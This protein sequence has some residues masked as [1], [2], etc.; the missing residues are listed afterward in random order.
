MKKI[1][2]LLIIPFLIHAHR[3]HYLI[4]H[5][6]WTSNFSW[7]MPGG[8]FYDALSKATHPTHVSFFLWSGKNSPK[9]RQEAAKKLVE[10]LD[11]HMPYYFE[12]N[13]VCH[14]HGSNVA[15]MA[16]QIMA[17]DPKLHG[18][19]KRLFSLGTPVQIP[20][21]APDM[22]VIDECYHLFSFNDFVQP[23][24]GVFQREYPAHDRIT[25][26]AVTLN[27]K[28]PLHSDLHSPLI[29]RWLPALPSIVQMPCSAG[30]IKF[31]KDR[32]PQF[33]LDRNRAAEY[34]QDSYIQWHLNNILRKRMKSK[35]L[36]LRHAFDQ[37]RMIDSPEK[38]TQLVP[39]DR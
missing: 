38:H 1:A 20:D 37:T 13:L 11:D 22:R 8:D 12:L 21:Y 14:S 30:K 33:D 34:E 24:F 15:N 25:N 35:N 17:E 7:H 32:H 4:I 39:Q 26:I 23:V 10:F 16:S 29:A 6:T 18:R 31:Y 9:A 19:I 27:G 5:G 2:F 36:P 28:E 3:P